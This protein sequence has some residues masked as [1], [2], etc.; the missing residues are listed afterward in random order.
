M[1]MQSYKP[2]VTAMLNYLKKT[3]INGEDFKSMTSTLTEIQKRVQNTEQKVV[4]ISHKLDTTKTMTST[5][6][7]PLTWVEKLN[8]AA[9]AQASTSII[10]TTPITPIHSLVKTR[11][12]ICKLSNMNLSNELKQR[13][14]A[15]LKDR[16]NAS[17]ISSFSGKDKRTPQIVQARI[18]PSGDLSV[19]GLKI[20]D[21]IALRADEA[22]ATQLC[23]TAKVLRP[24]HGAVAHGLS[25]SLDLSPKGMKRVIE[26]LE[27]QND[28]PMR[29]GIEYVEWL[30]KRPSEDKMCGSIVIHFRNAMDCN[31]VLVSNLIWDSRLYSC[32]RHLPEA[33]MKTMF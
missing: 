5:S 1:P 12:V 17:I 16:V 32:M 11:E 9:T 8:A 13:S 33:R 27:E 2:M 19:T 21:T 20:E 29:G 26:Q 25:K 4:S 31:K 30:N 3:L 18:L 14:P 15:Q 22:W 10:S 28:L 23:A 7:G 24:T 6:R